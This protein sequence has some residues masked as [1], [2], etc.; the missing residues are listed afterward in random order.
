MTLHLDDARW[1]AAVDAHVQDEASA[2]QA[3]LLSDYTPHGDEHRAEAAFLAAL[4]EPP[5]SD[6]N[7]ED[8]AWL[9]AAV[10]AHVRAVPEPA[11]APTR[12]WPYWV[13]S[14]AAVLALV[15]AA[16]LASTP[17]EA[18]ELQTR[19]P[20]ALSAPSTGPAPADPTDRWFIASGTIARPT[21]P[22]DQQLTVE[23]ELCAGRVGHSVC[24]QPGARITART[25]GDLALH[26]GT[27]TVHSN[28]A[29]DVR[30]ELD[31]VS[32]H[33]APHSVVVI[34]RQ[35]A[36][37][38]VTVREG[39][40]TVTE[41]GSKRRLSAGETLRRD[42]ATPAPTTARPK[43]ATRPTQ[44]TAKASTLLARARSQRRAGETGAAMQTYASLLR[45]HPRSAAAQTAR[46]S[47]AQLELDRNK[48]KAALRLFRAYRKRGGP[49][50]EDA[51]YGEIRALR[52]LGRNAEATRAANAFARR[53]P[54]S[55]YGTKLER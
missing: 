26:A 10:D 53:Y 47:L 16:A 52:A 1:R 32:V 41:L 43:V 4:A 20:V 44:P 11:P 27:A 49:L 28:D 31:D 7:E 18:H 25:S 36:G 9:L 40:V 23:S 2:E 13:A 5:A 29:E 48:P 6:P 45:Q 38:S 22:T 37:W 30:V 8:P 21:L 14:A 55:P 17:P 46:M 34:D 15:A 19:A 54:N 3:A 42:T 12:R 51:A 33:P 39:T 35:T 24:V 50:A